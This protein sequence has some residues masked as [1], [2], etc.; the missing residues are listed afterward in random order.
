MNPTQRITRMYKRMVS[1]QMWVSM[2][3]D[4]VKGCE[5][6]FEVNISQSLKVATAETTTLH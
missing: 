6:Y 2:S 4:L 1:F 3:I 5:S